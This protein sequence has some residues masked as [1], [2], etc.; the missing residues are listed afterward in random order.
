VPRAPEARYQTSETIELAFVVGLQ[1]MPPRQLAVL[2]LRD[3]LAFH[4]AEV[5]A[6]LGTSKTAVKASLQRARGSLDQHRRA[7]S[8][9][10]V[11]SRR[12]AD[13]GVLA[14]RFADA[15]H[16][17]DIDAIVELLTDD[18]WL[19]TPPAPHEYV[20]GT[21]IARFLRASAAWRDSRQFRLI[22]TRA[23]CQPA[24]GCYLAPDIRGVAEAAGLIVLSIEDDR[25]CTITRFVDNSTFGYFGLPEML[26]GP[27]PYP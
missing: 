10:Q 12:D 9:A 5:A 7:A 22:P 8:S 24:F 17:N 15:F 20:G 13:E 2:V 11:S 19:A 18:A 14:Q 3:V 23:N 27:A 21:A 25:I 4:V 1:H 16:A 6:M 26:D